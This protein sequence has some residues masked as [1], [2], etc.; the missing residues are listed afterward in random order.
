ME[1]HRVVIL[2][3]AKSA[4]KF[5]HIGILQEKNGRIAAEQCT[6]RTKRPPLT[7]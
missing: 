5:Q 7:L 3:I 1:G 2:K 4:R 6:M